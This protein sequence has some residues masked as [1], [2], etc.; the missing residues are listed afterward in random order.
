MVYESSN[1]LLR[2]E[3]KEVLSTQTLIS[4]FYLQFNKTSVQIRDVLVISCFLRNTP[5]SVSSNLV[6]NFENSA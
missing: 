6:L 1:V 2:A 4:H 5:V 3:F